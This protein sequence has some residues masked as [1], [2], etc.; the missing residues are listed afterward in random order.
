VSITISE[1]NKHYTTQL[2]NCQLGENEYIA[3]TPYSLAQKSNG[4]AFYAYHVL[5]T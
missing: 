5:I 1:Y 3:S 2:C 4:G